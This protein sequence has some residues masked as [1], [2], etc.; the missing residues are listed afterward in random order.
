MTEKENEEAL[1]TLIHKNTKL[2]QKFHIGTVI[3]LHAEHITQ[4]AEERHKDQYL[5]R[6]VQTRFYCY[7]Q[8]VYQEQLIISKPCLK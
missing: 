2:M 8:S 5:K 1:I 6:L 4:T 7:C 3:I